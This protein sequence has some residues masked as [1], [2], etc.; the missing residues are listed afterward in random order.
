MNGM[1]T[2]GR[3]QRRR[4]IQIFS[5]AKNII[6]YTLENEFRGKECS[7]LDVEG[8]NWMLHLWDKLGFARLVEVEKNRYELNIHSSYWIKFEN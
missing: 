5:K 1:K 4:A 3:T 8:K 2:I 6:S 7:R